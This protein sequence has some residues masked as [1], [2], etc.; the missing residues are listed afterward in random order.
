[1]LRSD[2]TGSRVWRGGQGAGNCAGGHGRGQVQTG[3]GRGGAG[4]V[5][6][7]WFNAAELATHSP[8]E[9]E[10]NLLRQ[11]QQAAALSKQQDEIQ[12]RLSELGRQ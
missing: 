11:P 7:G 12:R 3:S 9:N 6:C 5:R 1:M 8:Q 10:A 4:R 2:L